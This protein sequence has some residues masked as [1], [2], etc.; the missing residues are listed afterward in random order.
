MNEPITQ[1]QGEYR[2][3]SN[4]WPCRVPYLGLEYPSAENAYQAAKSSDEIVRRKFVTMSPAEA[5]RAGRKLPVRAD[6]EEVKVH[7]MRR[8]VTIKFI[9]NP[10][11]A[12]KLI[13]THPRQ[14]IE[15][16]TWGDTFWGQCPIGVGENHLGRILMGI[17]DEIIQYRL[18]EK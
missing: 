6:W 18:K 1:F 5:K 8:I 16:N 7:V 11:L 12:N 4:F 14:L 15:G 17:R 9:V 13:M 3:L 2:W 10:T